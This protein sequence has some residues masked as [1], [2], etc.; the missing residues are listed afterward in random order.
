MLL[1]VFKVEVV[2]GHLDEPGYT[3]IGDVLTGVLRVD[4]ETGAVYR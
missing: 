1:L 4:V 2:E 3:Y